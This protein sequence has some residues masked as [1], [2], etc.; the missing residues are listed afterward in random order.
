MN[1]KRFGGWLLICLAGCA[2]P[3]DGA[4]RFRPAAET[5]RA[6]VT[7]ALQDWQTG[8][9][10]GDVPADLGVA[11]RLVDNHR[12]KGQRLV[13]FTMLG[14]VPGDG[15]R[16]LGA[17]LTFA[18][19]AEERVIRFYVVGVDPLWIFRQEDY[20]LLLH[21]DHQMEPNAK[22]TARPPEGDPKG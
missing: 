3:S 9:A 12:L 17:R 21:W 18:D 20:D 15:P 8:H 7:A 13:K 16:S 14:E 5:A 11:V 1:I 6:A 19:P 2:K 10:P 4:A 22:S